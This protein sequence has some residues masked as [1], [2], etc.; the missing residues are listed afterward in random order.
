[1]V[2]RA[3]RSFRFARWLSRRSSR[4][5][6][7]RRISDL[8]LRS[9]SGGKSA[10]PRDHSLRMD[11]EHRS[12]D[13][14]IARLRRRCSKS[15]HMGD[16]HPAQSPATGDTP[17]DPTCPLETSTIAS[18]RS[19]CQC[20][21]PP[22]EGQCG[23]GRHRPDLPCSNSAPTQRR[24]RCSS[25]NAVAHA[26]A[27][28]GATGAYISLSCYYVDAPRIRPSPCSTASAR[29][30]SPLKGRLARRAHHR[31]NEPPVVVGLTERRRS[32]AG[33]VPST[34]FLITTQQLHCRRRRHGHGKAVHPDARPSPHLD[35]AVRAWRLAKL[36]HD[37]QESGGLRELR[38][39]QRQDAPTGR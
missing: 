19:E 10:T 5:V 18:R 8:G 16:A 22:G 7:C 11:R 29:E 9:S 35:G 28:S 17:G 37:V 23:R 24:P 13:G 39:N 33:P 21:G 36:R 15:S 6:L 12:H 31:T 26:T 30:A 25:R 2:D 34:S 4:S 20:L 32:R 14:G 3:G 27:L 1:M 38:G